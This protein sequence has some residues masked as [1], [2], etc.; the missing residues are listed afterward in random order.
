MTRDFTVGDKVR[1]E[2]GVQLD[3][4]DWGGLEGIVTTT[5]VK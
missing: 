2:P 3:G 4:M 5:W 1:V